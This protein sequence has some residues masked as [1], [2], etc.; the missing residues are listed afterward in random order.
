MSLIANSSFFSQENNSALNRSTLT[1]WMNYFTFK[2][3]TLK[4][5]NSESPLQQNHYRD[6]H[7]TE[8]LGRESQDSWNALLQYSKYHTEWVRAVCSARVRGGVT[9]AGR[10][11]LTPR[12]LYTQGRCWRRLN[13][14]GS[15]SDIQYIGI[16]CS[17]CS[18]RAWTAWRS[19]MSLR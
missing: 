12:F 2:C 19:W 11:S 9:A 16:S 17:D 4:K 15:F 1:C 10:E 13:F 14:S 8:L 5:F 3:I 7:V 18:P 6:K